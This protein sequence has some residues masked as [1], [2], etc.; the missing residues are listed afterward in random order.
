MRLLHRVAQLVLLTAGS[1]A[2]AADAA[3]DPAI[4]S[5]RQIAEMGRYEHALRAIDR[6][7]EAYPDDP[8]L[9]ALRAQV[10][11]V[12]LRAAGNPAPTTAFSATRLPVIENR[13]ATPG[14]NFTTETAGIALLWVAPGTVRLRNPQGSDDDTEVVL[15]RGFWLGRTEVTQ[16]QWRVLMDNIPTPS[17][18]KGYDRPVERISWMG[19][20]EFCRKLTER[21]R[22]AGRLPADYEYTLP[23]EAQWEY[24]CRAGTRP[25]T[26]TEIVALAWLETNSDLQT[27]PVGQKQPN[28]WGFYDLIGNVSEWCIDGYRGY[29]GGRVADYAGGYDGPSSGNARI[30]RG[31]S[32]ASSIGEARPGG[33]SWSALDFTSAG[34]GL[35]VALAPRRGT[36]P[37]AAD[38][39]E[40][41]GRR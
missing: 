41:P 24:A 39:G 27:H 16:E 17:Q 30:G 21:E 33:R 1:L 10:V 40:A 28:A 11:A 15:T 31:G 29:P 19:A 6:H 36:G 2:P 25:P 38:A 22:A 26:P 18:F 14:Q 32:W 37:V 35:R 34:M 8:R 12:I 4:D 20:M 3:R 9:V 13:R 5:L 7:L 23:S